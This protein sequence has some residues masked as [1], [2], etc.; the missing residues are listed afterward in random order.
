MGQFKMETFH[1]LIFLNTKNATMK[2]GTAE[3]LE[4]FCVHSVKPEF[5]HDYGFINTV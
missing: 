1:I 3:H 5:N 4:L 2:T